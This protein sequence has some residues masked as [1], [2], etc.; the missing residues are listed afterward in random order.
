MCS[1]VFPDFFSFRPASWGINLG[2]V[3]FFYLGR[4]VGQAFSLQME[5]SWHSSAEQNSKP[6]LHLV[7]TV[8]K[9]PW[10]HSREWVV[11]WLAVL[12]ST[13]ATILPPGFTAG[14]SPAWKP[15]PGKVSLPASRTLGRRETGRAGT[16]VFLSLVDHIQIN[17]TSS[18][19]GADEEE[20]QEILG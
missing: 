16:R 3:S 1:I 2:M 12:R 6:H 19:G 5:F 8:L 9:R 18:R 13:H 20:R 14:S 17:S 10:S 7:S 11:T 15:A 4:D